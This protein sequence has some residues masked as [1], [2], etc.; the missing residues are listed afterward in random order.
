MESCYFA[1]WKVFKFSLP[2]YPQDVRG[3]G[4]RGRPDRR[5]EAGPGGRGA[6]VKKRGTRLEVARFRFP[7]ILQRIS[8]I[9]T[10]VVGGYSD[11]LGD[12]QKCHCNRLS[13]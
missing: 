9:M 8:D 2:F 7:R 4:G 10:T 12:G 3:P 5:R 6:Q 1:P 13:L 11:T